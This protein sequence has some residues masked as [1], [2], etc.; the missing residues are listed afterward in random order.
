MT[1]VKK[2]FLW[3]I[4]AYVP[5]TVFLGYSVLVRADL[6]PIMS[7]KFWTLY[8]A[9]VLL[10]VLASRNL[11]KALISPDKVEEV[12]FTKTNKAAFAL[13]K[14]NLSVL[15]SDKVHILKDRLNQICSVVAF[16]GKIFITTEKH[17]GK[18]VHNM[19]HVT[20]FV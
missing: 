3:V 6:F 7:L 19:F 16:D 8:L 9:L 14:D 4:G 11:Y 17:S 13:V 10:V 18:T 15:T 1:N 12:L 5:V 2:A 20:D